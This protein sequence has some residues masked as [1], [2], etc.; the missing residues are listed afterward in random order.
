MAAMSSVD[1]TVS[2]N[3]SPNSLQEQIALPFEVPACD[4]FFSPHI[5]NAC[6]PV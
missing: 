1:G 4:L 6:L 3:A 2:F 5:T